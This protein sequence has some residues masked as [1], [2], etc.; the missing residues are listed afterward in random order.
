MET[1][2]REHVDAHFDKLNGLTIE[3]V[4]VTD[5]FVLILLSDDKFT[6]IEATCDDDEAYVNTYDQ[7]SDISD[8]DIKNPIKPGDL[9]SI[10]GAERYVVSVRINGGCLEVLLTGI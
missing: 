8:I 5:D 9:V 3:S 2:I 7:H 10:D 1:K 6:T 4:H